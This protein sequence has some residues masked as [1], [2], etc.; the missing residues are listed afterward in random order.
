[1]T[2]IA[3]KKNLS[4]APDISSFYGRTQELAELQKWLTQERCQLVILHGMGGI[5]KSALARR[6]VDKII[7]QYD[8]VIWLSLA[9]APPFSEIILKLMQFLTHGEQEADDIA[10]IMRCLHRH[11]CLIVLDSWEE[12]IEDESENYTKYNNFVEIVAQESHRSS[13]LL[14]T[15]KLTHNIDIL[16]GKLIRFKKLTEITPEAARQ[17]F[18]AEGMSGTDRQLAELSQRYRNPLMIKVVAQ[19]V[20]RVFSADISPFIDMSVFVGDAITKFLDEQ[21]QGLAKI[22]INLIY[23][24][25]I[26]RN[27]A[28]WNQLSHDSEQFLSD[29]QLFQTLNNLIARHSFISNN[30]EDI[31]TIYILDPVILKYTTER[32]VHEIFREILHLLNYQNL[33]GSEL[34]ITHSFITQNPQ[35]E[36]LNQE[37]MRRIVKP[38]QKMLVAKLG[39]QQQ[40]KDEL[41]QVISLLQYQGLSPGYAYQNISQLISVC[42]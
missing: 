39:S 2:Q 5:G 8:Y 24:L 23:W 27:S 40:L 32:F 13:L 16:K 20:K 36:E 21:F 9:S 4:E 35:D 26:R 10:P 33:Q 38:I 41:T 6:L 1:M 3:A 30:V 25:A 17:I 19:Q 37:Q 18:L 11:R 31:P 14:L 29:Q 34:L 12:L 22:E 28:T 42:Q 15:R 7:H